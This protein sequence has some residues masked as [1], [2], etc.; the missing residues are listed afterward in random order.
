MRVY[1]LAAFAAVSMAVIGLGDSASAQ[2]LQS[3]PFVKLAGRS[4][5]GKTGAYQS[6]FKLSTDEKTGKP[7]IEIQL[8]NNPAQTTPVDLSY[9]VAGGQ[10]YGRI[11]FSTPTADYE[12]SVSPDVNLAFT[13]TSMYKGYPYPVSANC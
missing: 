11:K 3:E 2:S 4:C 5:V 7:R 8:G 6:H 1:H 9:V 10:K 12:L 13:G